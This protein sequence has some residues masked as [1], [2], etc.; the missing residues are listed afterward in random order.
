[1]PVIDAD[2]YDVVV[3]Q[4]P[5]K[6]N[7]RQFTKAAMDGSV[8]DLLEHVLSSQFRERLANYHGAGGTLLLV[9]DA[10]RLL[11]SSRLGHRRP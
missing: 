8:P 3:V 1:M 4:D 7:V 5:L 9:G 11:E 2:G 6:T 10:V